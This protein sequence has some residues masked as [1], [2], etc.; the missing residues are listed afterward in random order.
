M[1]NLGYSLIES[2]KTV[3]QVCQN[4][5]SSGITSGLNIKGKGGVPSIP[6]N[7]F[8]SETILVDE[9]L[10]NRDI[11][12]I[13]TSLGDIYPARGIVKTEDGKIIL[14]AY[15]TDNLNPRTP[16]ISTNC[17]ISSIN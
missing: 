13:Q 2:E 6:T 9:P 5:R 8:N 3:A 16:Q 14:T 10:T 1:T 15:A 7:P 4:D 17:S 12:P 11:K